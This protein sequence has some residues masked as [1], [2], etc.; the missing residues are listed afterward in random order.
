MNNTLLNGLNINSIR[1]P[2][3]TAYTAEIFARYYNGKHQIAKRFGATRILEI[4]IRAGYSAHAFL[5]ANPAAKYIGIDLETDDYGGYSEYNTTDHALK[6]LKDFDHT[7][8]IANSHS[9]SK[10]YGSFDFIHIDADHSFVGAYMDMI[11]A[12]HSLTDNGVMVV[13]D[14]LHLPAVKRAVDEFI[15]QNKCSHELISDTQNGDMIIRRAK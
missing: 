5:T 4:G 7:I 6:L 13:D 1:H 8:L 11:L 15:V 10:L 3:E 2:K 14:Y 9:I 12:W